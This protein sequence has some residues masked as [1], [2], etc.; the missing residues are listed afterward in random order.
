MKINRLTGNCRYRS[1]MFGRLILQVEYEF[2]RYC[3]YGRFSDTEIKW[4]DA[5]VTDL[6]PLHNKTEIKESK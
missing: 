6:Q 3:K 5:K 1:G 4:R 2:C